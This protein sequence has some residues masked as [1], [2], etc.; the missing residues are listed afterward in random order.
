MAKDPIRIGIVVGREWSFPPA[1][2]EEVAQRGEGAVVAEIA[3][4]GAAYMDEPVPYRVIIDRMS[5]EI[6]YYRTYLKNAMLQ[7][8]HV[9][10]DPFRWAADD[11]YFDSSVSTKVGVAHPKTVALPNK[12]VK[13]DVSPESFRNLIYPLDWKAIVEYIGMPAILKDAHG[14]GW[15]EVYKVNSLEELIWRYDESESLTMVLQEFI[16]WDEYVRCMCIGREECMPIKYDPRERRYHRHETAGVDAA[17]YERCKR[18]ALALCKALGYD[19]NTVEFAVKDGIPYAID[20]MNPAPDMDIY[21]LTPYYFHWA[22]TH[23]ADFAIK[24]AKSKTKPG[25]NYTWYQA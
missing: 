11:K 18:D 22:I 13:A 16:E 6:P 5:H 17:L 8:T 23:L 21:S 15:K 14:G 1:F 7:G 12:E 2:I 25:K 10:N 9:I 20:F 3:Q 24:L 19:M 4:F